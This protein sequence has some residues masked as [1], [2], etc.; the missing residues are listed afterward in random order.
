MVELKVDWKLRTENTVFNHPAVRTDGVDKASGFAKYSTDYTGNGSLH[1]RL[2]TARHAHAM[3]KTLNVRDAKRMDGVQEVYVFPFREPANGMLY[4]VQWEGEPIVAVAAD[5]PAQAEAGVRAIEIAYYVLDHLVND[6]YL[7][8]ATELGLTKPGRTAE[9]GEEGEVDKAISSAAVV[10]RGSYGIQAITHCCLE[11]HGSTCAWEGED[12]LNVEL[13]TQNVSG[14]GGQFAGPLG[15]DAANVT[16]HCDYIGGGFGSKFA[17]DEWGLAC[18]E[19]AK[20]TKRPVQLHLDR[21]TELQIA[22][23]RPSAFADVTVAANQ[24]GTIVAW[25]SHHWGTDGIRGGTVT[26]VPYVIQP[27]LR[28]VRTTGLITNTGPARAWRAPNHPQ[29]CALT[30]TAIDDL[31]AALGMDPYDVFLKNLNLATGSQSKNPQEV[32]A[33]EMKVAEGLM[34]WKGKWKGRGQWDD[35]GWKRGLGMAI[36]TWGGRAGGGSCT[37][38]VHQDGT[39]ETFA[40]TQDL[41]TGTRTCIGQVV[42]ESFGL[43]LS[44]VQVNIG[45]SKY[46]QSGASG[47]STTIGGVS[48]PHRR[49]ALDALGKIFDKVAAKYEV[50][51]ASLSAKDG[52]I[53]N[54]ENVV[55]TWQQAAGLVGP[56]GLEVMGEGPKDDGLTSDGV[57]GVQMVDLSVDTETGRVK[58]NKYVAVQD[59]GTIVNHQLAKSQVLGAMIQCISYGLSEERIMDNA[60]GRFLNANLRDYKLPRIGDIGELVVEFYEPDSQYNKGVVGLGEPPVI[61]G[62]AAISNAVANAIG[63]RVPVLPLTP[64]RILDALANA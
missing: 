31:A 55:C 5:T 8:A 38:K 10:H 1:V 50:D 36:H 14:T 18:A 24:D 63:V 35:N 56:M 61:S 64:K 57:C 46:P 11:P 59:I 58:I 41:G 49:A 4:E 42:A 48:G 44:A 6:Q 34:D 33:E 28:R 37:I 21:P 25:D 12:K 32:Y 3:I 22:G 26:Q 27:K 2:L 19:I 15:I 16:V 13:S 45:S 39:V 40:G 43:P 23:S 7:E 54:G 29:A 51:A 52:K 30:S 47:G 62:G 17:A 60:S 20:A 9:E 53:L